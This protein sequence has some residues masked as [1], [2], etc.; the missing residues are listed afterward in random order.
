[1]ATCAI[2]R[3]CFPRGSE[4][5]RVGKSLPGGIGRAGSDAKNMTILRLHRGWISIAL[6]A[7]AG[8]SFARGEGRNCLGDG[9]LPPNDLRI[10]IGAGKGIAERDFNSALDRIDRIYRPVMAAKGANLSIQ[11]LWSDG[12]VNAY[13]E[14]TGSTW[15]IKMYGGLAR[16]PALTPDGFLLIACH[17]IGHHLG[18]APKYAGQWAANEGQA[19][20]FATLKCL[21]GVFEGDDNVEIVKGLGVPAPV[22]AQ[23][24]KSFGSANA[25]AICERSAMAGYSAAS[26]MR[27][28][29]GSP[30]IDFM[31]PDPS[32]VP[33]T[34]DG[35]PAAQCR[36]DTYYGGAICEVA[37]SEP[38]SETDAAPGTCAVET[39]AKRG[40]RPL[41]WYKPSSGGGGGDP[42]P[43]PT[44]GGI[45]RAPM[46]AGP[47]TVTNPY[48]RLEFSYDVSEFGDA[49]G[50]WLEFSAPN[51]DFSD[52]N[53]ITPDPA[54]SF[55]SGLAGKRGGF[56]VVPAY[57]LPGAG[58]YSVRIIPLKGGGKQAAGRFS[59]PARFTLRA[60]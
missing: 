27:A 21:R 12:T 39:G 2:A 58:A 4:M 26:V 40:T 14:R 18:G 34:A 22:V 46:L 23:C 33:R 11:R 42:N 25:I 1:M 13:A 28:L 55:G 54:R 52:P 35:H 49:D 15:T 38:L 59:N 37:A 9:F 56:Y 53:G 7:L 17:E 30:A 5:R 44:G 51:R 20:Y 32:A 3:Q 45:A 36:L 41:C 48:A 43:P 16:H 60:R 29:G 31:T 47:S 10:A 50:I 6:L 57:V 24:E 8:S 19:D